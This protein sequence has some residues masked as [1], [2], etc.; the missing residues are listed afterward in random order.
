MSPP[1][2]QHKIRPFLDSSFLAR[3]SIDGFPG[4]T[5]KSLR[6]VAITLS[7]A[8]FLLR[9]S[10]PFFMPDRAAVARRTSSSALF[11]AALASLLVMEVASLP[12]SFRRRRRRLDADDRDDAEDESDE[13]DEGSDGGWPDDDDDDDLDDRLPCDLESDVEE[14]D[15][16]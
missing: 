10:F 15:G 16:E 3:L 2:G 7:A 13:D 5:L 1:I 9:D 6:I 4:S 12:F 8:L 11:S 14:L